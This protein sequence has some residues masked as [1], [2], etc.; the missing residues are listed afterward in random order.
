[1]ARV[2]SVFCQFDRLC[3]CSSTGSPGMQQSCHQNYK[4]HHRHCQPFLKIIRRILD[5][6]TVVLQHMEKP[7]HGHNT[8]ECVRLERT[9]V[10][11]CSNLSVQAGSP[12]TQGCIQRFLNNSSKRHSTT[13]LGNLFQW[14]FIH[15]RITINTSCHKNQSLLSKYKVCMSCGKLNFPHIHKAFSV[16]GKYLF[17]RK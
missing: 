12:R 3:H 9:T 7:T 5:M 15:T 2:S 13:S 1:M 4:V 16:K 11:I 8:T 10:V 14:S 17:L 6:I